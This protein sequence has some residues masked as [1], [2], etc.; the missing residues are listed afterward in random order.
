[1]IILILINECECINIIQCVGMYVGIYVGIYIGIYI[2]I[3]V[4]GSTWVLMARAGSTYVL[5]CT[6]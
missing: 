2:G 4:A 5:L 1:M 6:K 3:H